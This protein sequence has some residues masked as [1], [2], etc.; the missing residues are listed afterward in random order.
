MK[1]FAVIFAVLFVAFAINAYAVHD[2][3]G[4]HSGTGSFTCT[5][6]TPISI[7]NATGDGAL[8][9]FVYIADE[10]YDIDDV[11]LTFKVSG[12]VSHTYYYKIVEEKTGA[13]AEL[14]LVWNKTADGTTQLDGFDGTG[15]EN[16]TVTCTH[17]KTLGTGTEE[18]FTQTVYVGYN[19]PL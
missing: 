1:K 7:D 3:T 2:N 15:T 11:T 14:T 12:Q 18:T 5:V 19:T 13:F 4:P 6:I 8:G 9:D 10:V 16:I 17:V